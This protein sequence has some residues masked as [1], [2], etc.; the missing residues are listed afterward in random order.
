MPRI[1]M[2]IVIDFMCPWSFIAMRSLRLAKEKFTGSLEFPPVEFVPFEFD[3]PGTYPPDGKDWTEYCKSYGPS[4]ARFLLEEKLPRAFALGRSVGI[5]FRMDRRIVDTV[6]VNTALTIAQRHGVAE[7]FA[8]QMLSRHFEHLENPN[9]H[10][11]LKERL[12]A[13]GVPAGEIEA[14]LSDPSRSL[15][16][17]ERTASARSL[18]SFQGSVPHFVIRCNG[19]EDL[20]LTTPGGPTSPQYFEQLFSACATGAVES[21]EHEL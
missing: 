5:E 12:V 6:D 10:S 2:T 14:E 9:D 3:P 18:P 15:R 16:N 7:A 21:R 4:K 13:L 19:G 17:Q 20:C 8:E 11:Q 1:D